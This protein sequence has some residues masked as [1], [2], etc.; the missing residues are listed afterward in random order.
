MLIIMGQ[1]K[2]EATFQRALLTCKSQPTI[3]Q[4][5]FTQK[6]VVCYKL[7]MKISSHLLTKMLFTPTL[8]SPLHLIL[9]SPS[10]P[11]SPFP[12]CLSASSSFLLLVRLQ[13]NEPPKPGYY[14][15]TNRKSL[16][17]FKA[18]ISPDSRDGKPTAAKIG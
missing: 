6:P 9:S 15:T 17:T 4:L 10:P 11:A 5:I 18:I 12:L 13:L 3:S 14:Y 7:I 1:G 2:Q 16:V 8:L